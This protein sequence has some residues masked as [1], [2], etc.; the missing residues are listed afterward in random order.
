MLFQEISFVKYKNIIIKI[1]IV[2]FAICLNFANFA[3]TQVQATGIAAGSGTG[4]REQALTNA[5]RDAI[6]QGIGIDLVAET[7]ITN[8][9]MDYDVVMTKAFG[10]V[11]KYKITSQKT[12]EDGDY[13]VKIDA[14]VNKGTP[15]VDALSAIKNI[16]QRK[17]SPRVLF[18]VKENITGIQGYTPMA[19]SILK[20]TALKSGFNIVNATQMTKSRRR[21]GRR[22]AIL[23]NKAVADA[24]KSDVMAKCDFLIIVNV[25]GSYGGVEDLYG[26]KTHNYSFDVSLEAVWPD[27]G[28]TVIQMTIP[29]TAVSSSNANA[30]Q[31]A[32]ASLS[33]FLYGK[34]PSSK[35]KSITNIFTKITA[36][37]ITELDLGAK[38]QI[39]FTKA[40]Q[41]DIDNVVKG[42]LLVPTIT[43]AWL[44]EFDSQLYSMIE[45][46][47]RLNTMQLASEVTK[48][49]GTKF[50]LDRSS[51]NY[52]QFIPKK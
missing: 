41:E 6:R 9:E 35:N 12:T 47:T 50:K 39:E 43:N 28:E 8:F 1:F 7:K 24:R 22:D 21:R 17:G 45:V 13:E 5:L 30:L 46:E 38:M 31:G 14:F 2:L 26:M 25:N 29:N 27:T 37:W 32:R 36:K 16:I 18:E 19:E 33:R 51:K 11:S 15:G 4:A 20:E 52:L 3:D 44:R 48:V 42:L 49:L 34:L 23:G 40:E 10:Y